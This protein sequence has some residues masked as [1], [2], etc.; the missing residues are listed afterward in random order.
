MIISGVLVATQPE[1]MGAVQSQLTKMP[2][3]DV[4]ETTPNGQMVV[5]IE[6]DDKTTGGV[7]KDVTFLNGVLSASLVY[8]ESTADDTPEG[9]SL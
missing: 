4:F 8:Q 2:G 7:L 3:V 1:Q 5:V 9:D 6:E